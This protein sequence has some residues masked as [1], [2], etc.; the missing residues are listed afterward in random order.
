[1]KNTKKYLILQLQQACYNSY[2]YFTGQLAR[3][4]RA[5]GHDVT[6]FSAVDEPPEAI[7]RFEGQSFDAVIDCNSV[8]PRLAMEGGGYFLD[9]LD[10]PFFNLLLDHPL[11]HHDSLKCGLQNYHVRCLDENHAAYVREYYPHIKSVGLW[12]ATGSPAAD[13]S[14]GADLPGS[15]QISGSARPSDASGTRDG[16]RTGGRVCPPLPICRRKIPVLFPGTFTDPEEILRAVTE[17]PAFLQS[18]L[19]LII[20]TLLA[21]PSQT[22]ESAIR[23]LG[24]RLDSYLP[25]AMPLYVQSCFLADTYVR[26]RRRRELVRA[27]DRARLPLLLVGADWEK[28]GLSADSSVSFCPGVPFTQSFS[29][30]AKSRITFNLMPE[31]KAGF[32]DRVFSA[33]LNGSVAATDP[34]ARLT[35]EFTDGKELLFYDAAE[36][37]EACERL[38][39]LLEQPEALQ[40]I[41]DAGLAAGARFSWE[42]LVPDFTASQ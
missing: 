11:Y 28:L 12:A 17:L 10:A 14:G 13:V 18:D 5:A 15:G 21:R 1:M 24:E 23:A 19:K 35:L 16:W 31:F 42:A 6:V 38:R 9:T 22:I 3:V 25:E 40:R 8:A 29:F 37:D 2:T 32:H 7:G 36:P 27:A 30:M 33:M 26:A 4:L 39:L 41:A 34:S 20:E